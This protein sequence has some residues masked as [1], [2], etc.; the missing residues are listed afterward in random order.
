[1][2]VKINGI[3]QEILISTVSV[4]PEDLP[5]LHVLNCVHCSSMVVQY[6]GK[7]A[8]IVPVAEPYDRPLTINKCKQCATRYT[9]QFAPLY[10][11]DY[12]TIVLERKENTHF[13]IFRCPRHKSGILVDYAQAI[14]TKR[15]DQTIPFSTT[16]PDCSHRYFISDIV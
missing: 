10:N 15:G 14:H 7:I 5:E 2:Q 11:G 12:T 4:V 1:M 6:Q 3:D 16:C 9:F 8:K 13:N